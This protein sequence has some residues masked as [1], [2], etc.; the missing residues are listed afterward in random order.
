MENTKK[1]KDINLKITMP[2]SKLA[3]EFASKINKIYINFEKNSDDYEWLD[4]DRT[5]NI[6]KLFLL[7]LDILN[8]NIT[9]KEYEKKIA[10]INKFGFY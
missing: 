5:E 2:I 7:E 6:A 3:L 9:L 4:G 10:K 1:E 8:G